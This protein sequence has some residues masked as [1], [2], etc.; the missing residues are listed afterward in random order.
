[1]K[2]L[3]TT[4]QIT[5]THPQLTAARFVR[6]L[7]FFRNAVGWYRLANWLVPSDARGGFVV[8]N[9]GIVFAG[10]IESFIDRQMYLFGNY[11]EFAILDFI[12]CVAESR[13]GVVL[14]IG[15]NVG[16][17]SL[18]FARHFQQVHSFEP[19]PTLWP[20]F[21]RNIS[22]NNL[23]NVTLHKVGLADRAEQLTL[24]LTDKSNYGLG[25]F[26]TVEQ[27]D[28]PLRASATCNVV[29][30]DTYLLE[31]NISHVDAVKVDVQGFEPEVLR[32][33][34]DLLA[35][36]RPVVWFELSTATH[37]KLSNCAQLEQL[38][39]Y[40]I[41]VFLIIP[42]RKKLTHSQAVRQITGDIIRGGD[43]FVLPK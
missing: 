40:P 5:E 15:A 16:T 29:V 11:D 26:S 41:E 34:H 39:P 20:A 8:I 2:S 35:H 32:G 18:A 4:E 27:Y 30:G 31:H 13:R 9:D 1:M 10:D 21:E 19:N 6:S 33:L 7:R 37:M 36:C 3:S 17:H 12:S 38:F 28:L 23:K 25:T 22:L 14:D 43:Y 24:Y 42:V